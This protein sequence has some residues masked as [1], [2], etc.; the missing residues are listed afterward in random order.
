MTTTRT[1]PATRAAG[2]TGLTALFLLGSAGVADASCVLPPTTSAST[3]TGIVLTAQNRDRIAQV[4]TDA[5]AEVMVLGTESPDANSASSVDR[6]FVPGARY[7]FHPANDASPF[8]DN[9]CT[10]T[11]QLTGP[12]SGPAPVTAEL[13]DTG[14]LG[15][16]PVT[17]LLM[18]PVGAALAYRFRSVV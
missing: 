12:G 5:G 6:T 11:R 9:A 13:P 3:F 7:E 14:V 16:L 4:R 18:L 10:A 15:Y 1:R 2:A 17:G 8:R